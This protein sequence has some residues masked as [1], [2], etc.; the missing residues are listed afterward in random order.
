MATVT[1]RNLEDEVVEKLRKRAKASNRSLEAEIRRI[2][3]QS[4][5]QISREELIQLAEHI[6]DM[7]P[8]VPQSDSTLLLR[9][10]RDSDHGRDP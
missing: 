3:S 4:A 9:E 5:S 8:E 1:I 10:D 2:L 6:R 7:T